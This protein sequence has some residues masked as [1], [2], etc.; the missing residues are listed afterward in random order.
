MEF[1]FGDFSVLQIC[2]LIVSAI[3]IG[4]NK[5]GIPGLG[6]IPVIMLV[7]TFET[8]ISTGLQLMMLCMADL[9]AVAYYH[10]TA[11]WKI[12]AKLLPAALGGI[13]IGSCVIH[14]LDSN[15]MMLLMGIVI[16]I[17]SGISVVR[18]IW[19]NDAEKIPSHW[20]FAVC[21]G[22]LAGF[23]TQIANA[24]GP[25]MALYLLAMRLPKLE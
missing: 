18:E 5:T 22:L 17:L 24:A 20:S 4:I 16:L 12:I 7:F 8:G 1:F 13:I 11:N 21:T 9:A 23:S 6:L 19:W 25:I 3:L 14:K 10:K 2:I 15:A